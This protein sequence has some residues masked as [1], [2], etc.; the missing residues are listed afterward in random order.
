MARSEPGSAEARG[1]GVA[2]SLS[3]PR[4][5]L[6]AARPK[7]L[8]AAAAPVLIGTGLAIQHGAFQ[9]LPAVAALV[10]ALLIQIATNL[11]NDYYDF[12][13]GTDTAERVGPTRVTQAGLVSPGDVRR[14]MYIV[15]AAAVLVGSYLVAIGGLPILIVGVLSLVCAVAYTGGPFPLGY[16]GLGDVFVF[17]FFGLVAVGGTYWVQADALAPDALLAGAGVGA[18]S[19][20]ILVAN[21]LRDLDTD[22]RAWKRTL[23]VR[24]GRTGTAVEYT[25]LVIAGAAVPL[26]GVARYGWPVPTIAAGLVALALCA[27]PMRT[28]WMHRDARELL[29]ALGQT[30]RAVALYGI[31]LAA[32][33]AWGL[34]ALPGT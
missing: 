31:V 33:L 27:A 32:V 1:A 5:W 17:V 10:G 24:L 29:P 22:T 25:L 28:V 11:A 14:A 7:T 26:I 8:A 19:T 15:L 12:V 34:R 21:N 30:A 13:R 6:L 23:A 20:A 4:V 3:R 2:P 16:H 18:L 9:G